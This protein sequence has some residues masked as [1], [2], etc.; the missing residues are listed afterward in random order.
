MYSPFINTR[1]YKWYE[2]KL[3]YRE[4]EPKSIRK[5]AEEE[6][7]RPQIK[8]INPKGKIKSIN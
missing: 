5:I 2:R 3:K 6:E 7:V 8:I 4:P 1:Y